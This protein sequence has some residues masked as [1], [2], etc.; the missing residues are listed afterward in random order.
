VIVRDSEPV[1]GSRTTS[2]GLTV[3]NLVRGFLLKTLCR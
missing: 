2:A 3:K 1:T